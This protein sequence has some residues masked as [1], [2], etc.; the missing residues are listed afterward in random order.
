MADETVE[1]LI[2]TKADVAGAKAAEASL[3]GVNQ[4]AGAGVAPLKEL[5][6][7]HE[8][9]E[10]AA[11]GHTATNERMALGSVFLDKAV[12][13]LG[14]AFPTLGSLIGK[15]FI[16][17]TVA[18]KLFEV[19]KEKLAEWNKELDEAGEKAA[20]PM[21]RDG[22]MA[23]KKALEDGIVASV[24]YRHEL[25]TLISDED[26]YVR[27]M[28]DKLEVLKSIH[29]AEIQVAEAVK[30]NKEEA[31][32]RAEREGK[33]TPAQA[34]A[35]RGALAIATSSTAAHDAKARA[36]E[37]ANAEEKLAHNKGL[38][39]PLRSAV[40]A[41]QKNDAAKQGA[42]NK[43]GAD[44]LKLA[45]DKAELDKKAAEAI[46][47]YEKR[48]AG[49][50]LLDPALSRNEVFA[51]SFMRGATG[52]RDSAVSARD[53]NNTAIAKLEADQKAAAAD[54]A[55]TASQR[56]AAE[57]DEKANLKKISDLEA[58]ISL[59]KEKDRIATGAANSA[60][61]QD[62]ERLASKGIGDIAG[63]GP[64]GSDV[65]HQVGTGADLARK[66]LLG[67]DNGRR[68]P[69]LSDV[70]K[71]ILT[72][73]GSLEA[74]H[75]VGLMEAAKRLTALK[76]SPDKMFKVVSDILTHLETKSVSQRQFQD[77]EKRV[78][79]L[80]SLPP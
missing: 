52:R 70:E 67:P 38:S 20:E 22:I 5:A 68:G 7:G 61:A 29:A 36:E 80:G 64:L 34:A 39:G 43:N 63:S 8:K 18:I 47:A 76:D 73:T 41:A 14:A 35:Q 59:L 28:Q 55:I 42:V 78:K 1:I 30:S 37:I 25:A 33:I 45:S 62:R 26:V 10:E 24:K 79:S 49:L 32:N 23:R 58:E 77:L 4:A 3:K 71:Q 27:K 53:S 6:K 16:P 74:G 48:L 2:K 66:E 9:A 31:I 40:D 19:A 57:G 50:H 56:A 44:L 65:V 13:K 72:A 11:K 51:A 46:M 21:F 60:G 54:A 69:A 75:N 15:I 12:H 17:L